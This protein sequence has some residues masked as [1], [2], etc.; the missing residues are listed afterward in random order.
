MKTVAELKKSFLVRNGVT[1]TTAFY[2]DDVLNQFADDAHQWAAASYKWPITE[3][4]VSTTF[5]SLVTDEDGF[6][7][8]SYPE[9]WKT[10]SIRQLKIGGKR[11]NKKSF[12]EFQNF[13][14]D[15]PSNTE[16][17]FSDY[18]QRY[19]INP[20]IDLSGTVTVWGQYTPTTLEGDAANTVFSNYQEEA[21]EAVVLKMLEYGMWRERKGTEAQAFADKADKKLAEV[22]KLVQDEQFGYQ[23]A[24]NDGMFER[25]DVVRGGFRDDIFKRDQFN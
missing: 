23:T 2:T 7:V 4:R 12:Y 22:W 3:G 16:R 24:D 5:A 6:W 9:G 19:Y 10:D 1:T 25:F 11:L 13:V 14:E 15:Q 21:N 20:N 17:I 18:S 8:G